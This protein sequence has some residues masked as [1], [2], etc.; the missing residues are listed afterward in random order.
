MAL[1]L[2]KRSLCVIYHAKTW[3]MIVIWRMYIFENYHFI[4]YMLPT[5]WRVCVTLNIYVGIGYI[6]PTIGGIYFGG[7]YML[8][9]DISCQLLG[10]ECK[11]DSFC[12][13]FGRGDGK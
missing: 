3:G 2:N 4:G 8:V 12:A 1:D 7:L 13:P 10:D 11:L 5:I 6:M 9:L